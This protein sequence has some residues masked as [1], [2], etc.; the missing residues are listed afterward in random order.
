ALRLGACDYL[1][2]PIEME[3]LQAIITNLRR[4][5]EKD[6]EISTPREQLRELGQFGPLLGASE[7]MQ[8]VYDLI[9]MVAP[10]DASV[11]IRGESGTGKEL[12]AQ[13]IHQFSGRNAKP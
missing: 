10:T 3:R 8:K 4:T 2:K 9:T 12:V 1:T 11:F 5:L 6:S 7:P 13:A